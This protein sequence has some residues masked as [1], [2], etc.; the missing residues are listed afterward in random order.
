MENPFRATFRARFCPMTANP[1]NPKWGLLTL[2]GI[3]SAIKIEIGRIEVT[4][5]L[6]QK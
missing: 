4:P 1:V 6:P 2:E 3:L 5:I